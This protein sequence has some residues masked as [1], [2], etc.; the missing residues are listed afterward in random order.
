MLYFVIRYI[1]GFAFGIHILVM[2]ILVFTSMLEDELSE[3]HM[4]VCPLVSITRHP[5]Y[6]WNE[7]VLNMPL[8]V[9]LYKSTRLF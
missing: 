1:D 4:C 7:W 8:S 9:K 5:L 3:G 2:Y 6:A